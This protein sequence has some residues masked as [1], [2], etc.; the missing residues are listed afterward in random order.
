[1]KV[2]LRSCMWSL[3]GGSQFCPRVYP[4]RRVSLPASAE[5]RVMSVGSGLQCSMLLGESRRS[6]KPKSILGGERKDE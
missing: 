2:F 3:E 6:R 1:M 5:A 4:A